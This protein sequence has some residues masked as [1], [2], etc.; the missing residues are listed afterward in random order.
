MKNEKMFDAQVS[1]KRQ[2]ITAANGVKRESTNDKFTS[3]VNMEKQEIDK[4]VSYFENLA[5]K[6]IFAIS[7]KYFLLFARNTKNAYLC[8][9]N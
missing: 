2:E 9:C 1:E 4:N 8:L 5:K 3:A 6:E 7:R